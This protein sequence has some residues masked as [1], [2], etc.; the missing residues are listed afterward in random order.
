MR[1]RFV[2]DT[3]NKFSKKKHLTVMFD[4]LD[5]GSNRAATD[6]EYIF[7][8]PFNNNE[9]MLLAFF[10]EYAHCVLRHKVPGYVKGMHWNNTTKMQYEIQITMAGLNFA[11][12]HGIVFSDRTVKW[13][14]KENCSYK[15]YT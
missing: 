9:R 3:I 7:L 5:V 8:G 15:D 2:L 6:G 1:K 4:W 13:L 11:Q 10:H 14:L 12:A